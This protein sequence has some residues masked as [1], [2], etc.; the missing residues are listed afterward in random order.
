VGIKSGIY[1]IINIVTG[2]VYVG[3]AYII[4]KRCTNHEV[5]LRLNRH[6]NPY[7]QASWNKYTEEAFIFIVLERVED[8]SNLTT[9]EQYWMNRLKACDRLYGFNQ[10]P[11]AG[12]MIGYKHSEE[13]KQAWSEYRQANAK[14]RSDDVKARIGAAHKGRVFSPET[15]AKMAAAKIGTKHSE[16]TKAKMKIKNFTEEGRKRISETSK[17]RWQETSSSI[18]HP[19]RFKK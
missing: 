6:V 13:T 7:L 2:K 15:R 18:G 12:S 10:A 14:P 17:R 1:A 8:L 16:E 3:Q 9:R 11:A 5:E 19:N 4:N